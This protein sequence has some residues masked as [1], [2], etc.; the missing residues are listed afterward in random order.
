LWVRAL[1]RT[2]RYWF[3]CGMDHAYDVRESNLSFSLHEA[4]IPTQRGFCIPHD[5][6]RYEVKGYLRRQLYFEFLVC[7]VTLEPSYGFPFYEQCEPCDFCVEV[8]GAQVPA[9]FIGS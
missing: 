3:F 2:R 9:E 1:W 7:V 8:A 6:R 4:S 5:H